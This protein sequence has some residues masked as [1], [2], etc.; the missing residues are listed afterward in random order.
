MSKGIDLDGDGRIDLA[1]DS[2]IVEG[3]WIFVWSG[4]GIV[5]L[6]LIFYHFDYRATYDVVATWFP[7]LPAIAIAVISLTPTAMEVQMLHM[8][9][10][11]RKVPAMRKLWVGGLMFAIF[12]VITDTIWV[13]SQF[14]AL[15]QISSAVGAVGPL[16]LGV[17]LIEIVLAGIC[18]FAV[19]L[20]VEFTFSGQLT[21]ML[22]HVGDFVA[23]ISVAYE[24]LMK[25]IKEWSKRSQRLARS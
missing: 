7:R 11:Q 24:S 10:G 13:H 8:T 1:T 5:S 17:D 21:N 25:G 15:S 18:G 22:V 9:K 3:A 23:L 14:G 2:S 6:A 4:I 12:D 19:A 16:G 20:A